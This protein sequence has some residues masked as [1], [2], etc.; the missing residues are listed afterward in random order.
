MNHFNHHIK[1]GETLK[2]IRALKNVN[3]LSGLKLI[4]K[5][6]V[7]EHCYYT[8]ILFEYFADKENIHIPR[9]LLDFVYRH[10][11]LESLTGDLL[12]PVKNISETSELAWKS[13]EY[14]VAEFFN[15]KK[16]TD[17]WINNDLHIFEKELV[18]LFKACDVLELFWFIKEEKDMGNNSKEI[19]IVWNNCLDYLLDV[20]KTPFKSIKQ[21]IEEQRWI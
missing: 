15:I 10:D 19:N 1:P 12:R 8:G 9:G 7:A 21:F 16:Y 20:N 17:S 11:M 6:S 13:I 4:Q 14:D 5:Y 2:M 3:R 18:Q